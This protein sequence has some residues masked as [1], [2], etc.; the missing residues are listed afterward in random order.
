MT[1]NLQSRRLI[2]AGRVIKMVILC[3]LGIAVNI[4]LS[5]LSGK[6]GLPFYLDSV[7]TIISAS[8]GGFLPGIIVGLTTNVLKSVSDWPSIYYGTLNVMIAVATALFTRDGFK[9]KNILPLIFV[10]AAIGGLLGSVLTWFLFGFAGEGISADLATWIHAHLFGSTV[11]SQLSADFC[12]DLGDKAISVVAAFL[13]LLIVPKPIVDELRFYG[14]CQRPLSFRE[15]KMINKTRVRQMSLRTKLLLLLSAAITTIAVVS[16]AIGYYL[17]RETTIKDHTE[18]ARGIVKYQADCIDPEMIDKYLTYGRGLPEYK[19]TEEQLRLTFISSENIQFMYVYQVLEDGCRV[20]FDMDTEEV[21][22]NDPGIV[23]HHPEDIE[24]HLDD[25]LAGNPVEPTISNDK[26]F[27]WVLSVYEPIYDKDGRC[28]CYSCADISMNQLSELTHVYLAKEISLFLGIFILVLVIGV[29]L[30]DYHIIF[31][32]NSMSHGANTFAYTSTDERNASVERIKALDIHTGDEIENLY[33]A[34]AQTTEESMHYLTES[35][36]KSRQ[37]DKLQGGLLMVLADI[38]ESRDKCTGDHIRKT[39]EYSKIILKKLKEQGQFPE[40]LTDE[41]I[42]NVVRAAPLHDIG[43]INIPDAI[44][45]SPEKLTDEQYSKMKSHT[46]AGYEIIEKAIAN[47]EDTGYLEQAKQMAH[48]HHERWDGS[49]YPSH[50]KGEEIPLSAR[51]MAVADV[52]DALMS[53]RSYKEPFT[54]EK[55][56]SLIEEGAGTHFDP[57]VVAAFSAAAEEVRKV[58]MKFSE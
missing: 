47:L 40:I 48:Y 35:R 2:D 50:L 51:I 37:I 25:F 23:I 1:E 8:I 4:L 54:F 13:V 10:L 3:V 55:A 38:I 32:L 26:R 20:V 27:G 34:Y 46:V 30:A 9:K 42:G 6:Y 19:E 45:N 43:K 22:A 41:Y 28:V 36:R 11:L 15:L 5:S 56:M 53:K 14:W 52:F 12:I 21:E 49:G 24:K 39:A 31:P 29:W 7:G 17:F 44:L 16:I 18:F 58:S 33:N 57:K